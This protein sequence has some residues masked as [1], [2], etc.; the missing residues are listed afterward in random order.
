MLKTFAAYKDQKSCYRYLSNDR[1][2]EDI[3]IDKL[4]MSCKK[5]MKDKRVLAICDTSVINIDSYIG[6]IT[7]FEGLGLTGN[8]QHKPSH[9]FFIHPILV[10]DEQDDSAYGIAD[11]CLYN[12]SRQKSE[13]NRKVRYRG[14]RKKPIE[15]KESNKWVGPCQKAKQEVLKDTEH[16][17]FVMDREADIWEVFDRIP[18]SRTDV[19]VRSKHD[20]RVFTD[21]G[22]SMRLYDRLGKQQIDSKYEIKL[23]DSKGTK[24]EVELKMGSCLLQ[25]PREESPK[26]HLE[27]SYVE[28]KQ[29]EGQ[30]DKADI[31]IHWIIW[32]NRKLKS[33]ADGK[34]I[35]ETYSKRWGIEVFFKLL[36]T[37]G[38]AIENTQLETGKG[39]RKLTLLIM[40]ASIKVLQLKAA[41]SG[42]SEM[43][44]KDVFTKQETLCLK[45]LNNK[46]QGKTEKQK[47][48]YNPQDLSWAS[49]IIARLAGWTGFYSKNSPPG[50]K[51]FIRGLDRFESISTGYNLK[52]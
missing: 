33:S 12:R 2:T 25:S 5:H 46:L 13:L 6:R 14:I 30:S 34:N 27:L 37:D 48:P 19:V 50:N 40:D 49:W 1:V 36:K 23:N 20:R 32:T 17:T 52:I 44:V 29:V 9:G 22:Q 10:I 28:I 16:V 26:K 24:V 35:I 47:N 4:R 31:E 3:L 11:I 18:D 51:V 15:E 39:I 7:D 21:E 38:Y 42:E 41:R 8:N 43:K 45:A